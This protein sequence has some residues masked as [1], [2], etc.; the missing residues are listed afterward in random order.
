LNEEAECEFLALFLTFK[1]KAVYP[2]MRLLI[3]FRPL[4]SYDGD[5]DGR[6]MEL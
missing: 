5:K 1:S 4:S 3:I 6:R 2:E